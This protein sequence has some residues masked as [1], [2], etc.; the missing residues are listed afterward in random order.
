MK[1]MKP[2]A[3]LSAAVALALCLRGGTL[4][5]Y[6][7]LEITFRLDTHQKLTETRA[8][9][10]ILGDSAAA[11][12]IRGVLV[13][14]LSAGARVKLLELAVIRKD[15]ALRTL[16]APAA[17]ES[18]RTV[19]WPVADASA[20][21]TIRFRVEQPVELSGRPPAA[22]WFHDSTEI[23]VR[24][25]KGFVEVHAATGTVTVLDRYGYQPSGP[26]HHWVLL[27]TEPSAATSRFT[28]SSFRSQTEA[29]SWVKEACPAWRGNE[30]AALAQ[31]AAQTPDALAAALANRLRVTENESGVGACRATD[32]VLKGGGATAL[33]A[34]AALAGVFRAANME[35]ERAVQVDG[36][37]E[38]PT[39]QAFRRA[40]VR[41]KWDG[42]WVWFDAA[43]M[44]RAAPDPGR[45][46]VLSV[47]NGGRVELA[48]SVGTSAVHATMEAWVLPGGTLQANVRISSSG[49]ASQPYREAFRAQHGQTDVRKL[50]GP[51]LEKRNLR[52]GPVVSDPDEEQKPFQISMPVREERFVVPLE[53]PSLEW[54]LLT[55]APDPQALPG[56][57]I[58]IGSPG[59]YT[60]E[61]LMEAAGYTSS[62]RPPVSIERPFA[63]YRSSSELVDGRLRITRALTI[64]SGFVEQAAAAE[65]DELRRRVQD[66]QKTVFK[67]KRVDYSGLQSWVDSVPP[68]EANTYGLKAL[69]QRQFELARQ[70]FERVTLANPKDSF[71]WNNM[72][73]ALI[74]LARLHEA[75]K[76]LEKQIEIN[77]K[78]IY[79]YNNLGLIDLQEGK[80][81]EARD[82]FRK[83]LEIH[84][85]DSYA[86]RNLPRALDELQ[87]WPGAEEAWAAAAAANPARSDILVNAASAKVCT[88]KATAAEALEP[89]WAGPLANQLKNNA[90]YYLA[91][92]GKEL[93]VAERWAKD[94]NLWVERLYR[95]ESPR[96]SDAFG[97]QSMLGTYQDTLGWTYWKQGRAELALPP[98]TNAVMLQGAPVSLAHLAVV[99]WK[100]GQRTEA[101]RNWRTAVERFPSI[102]T[103][104]PPGIDAELRKLPAGGS[105][106]PW[107]AIQ[108]SPTGTGQLAGPA[109]A[110]V[111]AAPEGWVQTVR[112]IGAQASAVQSWE[113]ELKGLR[114]PVVD[115]GFGPVPV[116]YLV[117]IEKH[118]DGRTGLS[119]APNDEA[120]KLLM[121]LAPEDFQI[122]KPPTT[123]PPK[124]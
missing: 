70:L 14:R 54:S 118:G 21:D 101:L 115:T 23:P 98:L 109:Y 84:P 30:L 50:F 24:V 95:L 107:T 58:W 94:A 40:L 105:P 63:S 46:R 26:V 41:V 103:S 123:Q 6:S 13:P 97:R 86:I 34:Q 110:V 42:G 117:K 36:A 72:G 62:T 25:K 10:L 52:A 121:Q 29:A 61:I 80:W 12:T 99:Q 17:Q 20:G 78:D 91:E 37:N 2:V 7:R 57:R 68:R 116:A 122:G 114:F 38:A 60:E 55:L 100:L 74:S 33:E 75:R 8:G 19:F 69:E 112:A 3:R 43:R 31:G 76:A 27:D 111:I 96:Y 79:A 11:N 73:R 120:V 44:V 66:D 47:D 56:S 22:W 119:R 83:Q 87:D 90:A 9:E 113:A 64:R 45:Q 108:T 81:L 65:V 104:L 49:A 5:E 18:E 1:V 32:A 102:R 39:P 89:L 71:A 106:N 16:S 85:G 53:Q 82:H 77:A 35:A 67:L 93:D 88:G 124:R 59:S 51:F 48:D 15:G 4:G 92:C 28:I